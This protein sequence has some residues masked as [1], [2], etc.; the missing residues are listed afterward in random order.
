MPV[1][2]MNGAVILASS[3]SRGRL[4]NVLWREMNGRIA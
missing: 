1:T 3:L 4:G 2:G